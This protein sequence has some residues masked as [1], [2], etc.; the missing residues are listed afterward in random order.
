MSVPHELEQLVPLH[1]PVGRD[2]AGHRCFPLVSIVGGS[3]HVGGPGD[4]DTDMDPGGSPPETG[5]VST[6][7]R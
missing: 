4:L 2:L 3:E 7:G 1:R 6:E 5:L